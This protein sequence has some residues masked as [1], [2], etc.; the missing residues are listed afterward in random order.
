MMEVAFKF[1]K[2]HFIEKFVMDLEDNECPK[3][4]MAKCEL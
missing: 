4:Q 2:K 3:F 1:S